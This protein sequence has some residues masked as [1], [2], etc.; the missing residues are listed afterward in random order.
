MANRLKALQVFTILAGVGAVSYFL[1]FWQWNYSSDTALVGMV[2]RR[3]L[4][5]GELPIFVGGVGY[6]GLLL[7]VPMAAALFKVFGSSPRV[8]DLVPAF[9][10]TLLLVA[11]YRVVRL[12]FSQ[13]VGWLSVLFLILS[14]PQWYGVVLRS[15]PN[16]PQ[17]YLFGLVLFLLYR[18]ILLKIL[19]GSR[20]FVPEAVAFGLLAGFS[21]YL[22]GQV[23]YFFFAIAL[24]VSFFYL[25]EQYQRERSFLKVLFP[26][27]KGLRGTL[28]ALAG[29]FFI[30]PLLTE[31]PLAVGVHNKLDFLICCFL[32]GLA[33]AT[34]HGIQIVRNHGRFLVSLSR[35]ALLVLAVFIV[36]YFPKI[37]YN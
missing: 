23:I 16:Y 31:K 26:A 6:Q 18:A 5:H 8:L 4:S 2:A 9:F 37:Y 32:A 12:S 30:L 3:F 17:T 1:Y 7:E 27:S 36:G 15:I 35:M 29:G 28:L 34:A 11:L 10:Y 13:A 33:F 24:H 19:S 21:F 20:A 22:Y 14:P 25:R